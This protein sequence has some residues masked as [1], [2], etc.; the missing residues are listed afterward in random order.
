MRRP[1]SARSAAAPFGVHQGT[2]GLGVIDQKQNS[3]SLDGFDPNMCRVTPHPT[4][5]IYNYLDPPTGHHLTPLSLHKPPF[6]RPVG[7]LLFSP[8]SSI[9]LASQ[10]QP[11]R[12]HPPHLQ[13][14]HRLYPPLQVRPLRGGWA[15]SPSAAGAPDDAA[16]VAAGGAVK[17][18][19]GAE[20]V[21]S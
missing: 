13:R 1:S 10:N 9:N 7:S 15:A 8:L 12:L 17:R 11:F 14:L 20:N 2:A 21:K 3:W 18:G 4:H 19:D 16:G 5:I 6:R